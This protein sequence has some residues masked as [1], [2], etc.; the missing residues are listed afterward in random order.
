MS[1]TNYEHTL[2]IGWEEVA[3][4]S[5]LTLW[6]LLALRDGPKQMRD[7]KEFVTYHSHNTVDADDKSMY[8]SLRRYKDSDIVDYTTR[9][10]ESGPDIKVYHLTDTGDHILQAFLDRSILRFATDPALKRLTTK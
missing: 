2:L 1:L 10:S 7:I 9:P 4:K 3:K 8:R 6:I 5:Q